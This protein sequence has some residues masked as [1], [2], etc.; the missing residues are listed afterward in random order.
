MDK[1]NRPRREPKL[2]KV[3]RTGQILRNLPEMQK[4]K[5]MSELLLPGLG[6]S[7]WAFFAQNAFTG[8]SVRLCRRFDQRPLVAS[9]ACKE[10][11]HTET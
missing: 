6:G 1:T 4:Q 3:C 10:R 11:H 7:F 8:A 5:Q 2:G 9:E